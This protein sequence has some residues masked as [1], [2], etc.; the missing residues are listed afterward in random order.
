VGRTGVID[1]SRA[2]QRLVYLSSFEAVSI[3][4]VLHRNTIAF[5]GMKPKEE[6]LVTKKLKD[7]FIALDRE[8]NL[9][10]W[11]V[12]TGK[13]LARPWDIKETNPN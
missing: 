3:V 4:P 9:T 8:N 11:S 6:Y 2:N 7:K 10:T 13:M 12:L 1:Y 5:I